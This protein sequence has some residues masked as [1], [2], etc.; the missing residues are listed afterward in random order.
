MSITT[1]W[2]EGR[3]L[4]SLQMATRAFATFFVALAL[5]RFSEVAEIHLETSGELSVV[6]S[7]L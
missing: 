1:F 4:D 3:D 6:D 7:R 5:I 2:G